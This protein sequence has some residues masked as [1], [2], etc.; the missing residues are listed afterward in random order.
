[1][2]TCDTSAGVLKLQTPDSW[3][4]RRLGYGDG[5]YPGELADSRMV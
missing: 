4:V 3:G 5:A 2:S 1:M